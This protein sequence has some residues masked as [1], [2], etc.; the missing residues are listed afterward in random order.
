MKLGSAARR[1]LSEKR[2]VRISD[3]NYKWIVLAKFKITEINS[4]KVMQP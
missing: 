3:R 4:V 1:V 2:V